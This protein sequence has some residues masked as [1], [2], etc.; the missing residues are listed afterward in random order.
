MQRFLV[1]KKIGI[2]FNS[3]ILELDN[4]TELYQFLIE[5]NAKSEWIWCAY[6]KFI[7]G[8]YL[9]SITVQTVVSVLDY[10]IKNQQFDTDH[11]YHAY[12]TL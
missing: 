11:L 4:G 12:R 10:W 8:G 2:E 7:M 5:A 3:F 9:I 1:Q 6:F